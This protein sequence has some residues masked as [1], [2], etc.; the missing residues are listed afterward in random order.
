MVVEGLKRETAQAQGSVH[1]NLKNFVMP[2][3]EDEE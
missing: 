1:P 2:L 3:I